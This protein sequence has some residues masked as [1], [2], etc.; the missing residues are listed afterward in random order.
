MA[1]GGQMILPIVAQT[2][3]S[4]NIRFVSKNSTEPLFDILT[5]RVTP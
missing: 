1:D 4:S 2:D 5:Y 3:M